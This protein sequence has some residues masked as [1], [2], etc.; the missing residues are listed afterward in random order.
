MSKGK[1]NKKPTLRHASSYKIAL[2]GGGGVGKTALVFRIQFGTFPDKYDP[3]IED[4]YKKDGFNVDGEVCSLEIFD[5]AGQVKDALK[6]QINRTY[7]STSFFIGYVCRHEGSLL[8][9][10]RWIS[11]RLL[12][13]R[14]RIIGGR[15][16]EV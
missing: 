10:S 8:Q 15:Q 4:S 6:N 12:N 13:C 9:I 7:A 14:C 1:R 11:A 16:G 5:T 2:L 3:T